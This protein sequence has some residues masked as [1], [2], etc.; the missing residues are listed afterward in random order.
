MIWLADADQFDVMFQ[1]F[2]FLFCLALKPRYL[3]VAV[4]VAHG[5]AAGSTT[6]ATPRLPVMVQVLK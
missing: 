1:L 6:A 5:W 3:M 2:F 4:M